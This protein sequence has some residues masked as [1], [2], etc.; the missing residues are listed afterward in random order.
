MHTPIS[1][2][3]SAIA[4]LKNDIVQHPVYAEIKTIQHVRVCMQYHVFAVWD[5]MSLL[6]ALQREL[7]CV[8]VPW[9]PKG[10]ADT[11]YLI[12]EIVVGEEA[13]VD[14]NGIRKSHFELYLDAMQQCGADTTSIRTFIDALQK[15]GDLERAFEEAQVP[16]AAREF[17]R[18]TFSIIDSKQ[19]HLLSAVFTFGREDLIPGMFMSLVNDLHARFPNSIGTFKYY[20]ERHIEVDGDH[21]S[22]LALQMTERLCTAH[23]DYTDQALTVV[24]TALEKR[25]R[26]WSGFLEHIHQRDSQQV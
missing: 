11:R 8:Q 19:P 24:K 16:N 25:M 26:L 10:F 21:H 12:N 23:P 3:Q 20:L 1:A 15:H 14:Q 17:V 22:Q 6:K 18:F 9:F 5:F 7:T 13:D 4:P 2:I